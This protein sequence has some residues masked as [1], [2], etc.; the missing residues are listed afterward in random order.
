MTEVSRRSTGSINNGVPMKIISKRNGLGKSSVRS[1]LRCHEGKCDHCSHGSHCRD[2]VRRPEPD[3]NHC[4]VNIATGHH[5]HAAS[6]H[7]YGDRDL[8]AAAPTRAENDDRTTTAPIVVGTDIVPGTY[9]TPGGSHCY[10]ARLN[11][12]DT[13]DII[14]NNNNSSS[15]GPQ[16]VDIMASDRAFLTQ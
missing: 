16:S 10:W 6:Y 1:T 3:S 8:H 2:H 14:D 4:D 7:Q 13:G 12:L 5:Q 11:S 15:S 9:H